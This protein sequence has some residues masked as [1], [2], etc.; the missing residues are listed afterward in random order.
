VYCNTNAICVSDLRLPA[1][2][3]FGRD[4]GP[5]ANGVVIASLT[6]VSAFICAT[7]II[8]AALATGYAFKGWREAARV[9]AG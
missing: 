9:A 3:I 2:S 7:V 5:L 1:S 6:L 4:F 8:S